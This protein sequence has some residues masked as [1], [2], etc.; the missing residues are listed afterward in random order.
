[1]VSRKPYLSK[2]R[3]ISAWQ[4]PKKLHLEKHNPELGEVSE[5]T[6]SLF[7]T[8]HQVGD[9]SQRLYGTP[10]S[11]EI[12]FNRKMS[13]MVRET[14]A[15]IDGGAD[16]PIFEATFQHDGV[17]VR[18]DVLIPDGNGWRAIEVKASTSVK[19]YH[20][21]DC[22]IQDWV[23]RHVG[24]SV[25]SM[26]LAHI[27]NQFLYNG[28]GD[29]DGLLA[30]VDLTERVRT[31]EPTV[32]MLIEK[33]RLAVTGPLPVVQVGAHCYKPY[34][35]QF[36]NHCWPTDTEYPVAGL[37]GSKAKLGN[38]VA[39]G[40]RDV[41]DVDADSIT[42][43]TQQRIHRI[44][45]SGNAETLDG[46][47]RTLN[48]LPYPRYYLDFE[49]IGPAVPFWK[50]TRPYAPIP[51]QWS[52]HIDDGAGD[53][54]YENMQHAEFLD[55]SGEPPMR[56]L[57]EKM[58]RCLGAAGPVLMY[59]NYEEQ[60]IESLIALFPDLQEPLKSIVD[61][62]F[63]LH[64]VVKANYYHPKMLGSWSIKAVL[65]TI[66]PHMNYAL[67]DGIKEGTAA[68]EGFI[69]AIAPDTSAERKVELEQQLLRYCRFDTQAMAAIVRFLE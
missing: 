51:I 39:L 44:T 42:A 11:V 68:S 63:D 5:R 23:M 37:G 4:C 10:D 25:T 46:A 65:P 52:C 34:E 55:L 35:C 1:M 47:R 69:E 31:V 48:A 41:R 21:L 58:I 32:E 2:S 49:T 53:G 27:N 8:G 36:I 16:F 59:T 62:L 12:P 15:L 29:Y 45:Q 24:L 3:V 14:R 17:L 66:A 13:M 6:E 26:S 28:D 57:A 67:L 54:S 19:D 60:V 50:G 30:E 38:Y 61:R 20:V 43:E 22:A 9:I 56:A 7:A 33:A 64:P 18:V 40:Y